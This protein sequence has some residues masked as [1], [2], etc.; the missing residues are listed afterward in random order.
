M[1]WNQ[2]SLPLRLRDNSKG[3]KMVKMDFIQ[4]NGKDKKR[5]SWMKLEDTM[6]L[7]LENMKFK[8]L[9]MLYPSMRKTAWWLPKII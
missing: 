2:M 8:Q 4:I 3:D 9:N 1:I 7:N 5:D 6:Q